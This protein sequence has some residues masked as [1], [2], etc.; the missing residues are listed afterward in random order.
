MSDEVV[1][2][3]R[4]KEVLLLLIEGFSDSEIAAELCISVRTVRYH[5]AELRLLLG[6][7]NRTHLVSRAYVLEVFS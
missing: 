5:I 4:Q 7:R 2:T 6:A 3:S 1:P